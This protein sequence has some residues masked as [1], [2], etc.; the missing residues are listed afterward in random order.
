MIGGSLAVTEQRRSSQCPVLRRLHAPQLQRENEVQVGP[1][2]LLVDGTQVQ[3]DRPA[4]TARLPLTVRHVGWADSVDVD[5]GERSEE[6]LRGG[7]ERFMGIC[8]FRILLCVI[9]Y[10]YFLFYFIYILYYFFAFN[11]FFNHFIAYFILLLF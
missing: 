8:H 5:H 4:T 10:H 3:A 9:F 11:L 2:R 1:T 7:A 6:D